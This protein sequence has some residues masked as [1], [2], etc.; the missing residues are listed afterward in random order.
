MNL[1]EGNFSSSKPQYKTTSLKQGALIPDICHRHHRRR[2]CKFFLAGVNIY[3]FNAKNWQFT[4][5]FV[6]I[7]A[8]FGVNF[9]LQKFCLCKKNDKYQVWLPSPLLPHEYLKKAKM[10]YGWQHPTT[11]KAHDW[12]CMT[13]RL[14]GYF[15]SIN[16]WMIE[17][18]SQGSRGLLGCLVWM[19]WDTDCTLSK[20]RVWLIKKVCFMFHVSD[21]RSDHIILIC[22]AVTPRLM[23]VFYA[24]NSDTFWA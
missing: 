10:T 13:D 22:Q 6:V 2:L 4:V 23:F 3:R 24:L 19:G 1:N 21:L 16:N 8:F 9:I 11:F 15:F 14:D 17:G 18:V 20:E 7:Y 5:Y 12:S